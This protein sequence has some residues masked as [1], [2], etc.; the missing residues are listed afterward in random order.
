MGPDRPFENVTA[1]KANHL[2][3]MHGKPQKFQIRIRTDSELYWSSYLFCGLYALAAEGVVELSF[4][5]RFSIHPKVLG[6]WLEVRDVQTGD[7]RRIVV[8]FIDNANSLWKQKLASCDVYYKRNLLYPVT[9]DACPVEY[10][11]KLRPAGLTFC[12]RGQ[13]E[14]PLWVQMIG[15]LCG[16][17]GPLIET[18]LKKTLVRLSKVIRGP[19]YVRSFPFERAFECDCFADAQNVVFFQTR[20]Y[21]PRV[22]SDPLDTMR[23]TERR[24]TVIR[25]LRSAL[26]PSFCGGFVPDDYALKAYPDCIS[27]LPWEQSAYLALLQTCRIVVYTHGLRTSPAFKM[28]EYLAAGRCILSERLPTILPSPLRDGNELMYFNDVDELIDKC[29]SLLSNPEMQAKLSRGARSYYERQV[30]PK[31]RVLNL[32]QDAFA[33]HV[34]LDTDYRVS[35]TA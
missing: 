19:R 21:D 4:A 13:R 1:T 7:C 23:V 15:G 24:A 11:E 28:P 16:K 32:L 12:V 34:A 14:R 3:S 17:D 33:E 25:A 5:P 30:A 27:P 29:R 18:S 6:T 8:N 26:G 20:A 2:A 10:H 35:Q 9:Y 31:L 22:S